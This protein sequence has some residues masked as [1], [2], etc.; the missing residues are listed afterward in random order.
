MV[1]VGRKLSLL[2]T[3]HSI[4][5]TNSHFRS[6]RFGEYS[7]QQSDGTNDAEGNGEYDEYACGVEV[8]A[9]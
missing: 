1:F 7:H 2:F 9:G 4:D 8:G 3:C 5:N 6:G